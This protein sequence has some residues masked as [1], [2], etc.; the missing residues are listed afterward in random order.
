MLA[1][2]DALLQTFVSPLQSMG[3]LLNATITSTDP[4]VL[5][6][7]LNGVNLSTAAFGGFAMPWI[8]DLGNILVALATFVHAL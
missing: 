8:N 6:A 5:G 2:V 4:Y 3:H 7:G 1:T